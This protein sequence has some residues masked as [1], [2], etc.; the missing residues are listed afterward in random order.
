M[1][2]GQLWKYLI[3]AVGEILLVVIGILIALQ[4]NNWNENQK[5]K[6]AITVYLKSYIEDLEDDKK[7]LSD[8]KELNNFRYHSLQHLLKLAGE[9]PNNPDRIGYVVPPRSDSIWKGEFPMEFNEAFIHL[10][11]NYSHRNYGHNLNHSTLDELKSIG[12]YSYIEDQDLKE[13]IDDYYS[14]WDRRIGDQI[15]Q[16]NRALIEKW[17]DSFSGMGMVTSDPFVV[18]NPLLSIKDNP[19]AITSLRRLIREA[20]WIASSTVVIIEK[21]DELI[22]D[23]QVYI[24]N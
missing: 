6:K 3:Y 23:I 7:N 16:L 18:E 9:S 12:L 1:D 14:Q 22:A 15:A 2:E 13:S 21:A 20:G 17:Q 10:A 8:L 24:D 19:V 5:N 11:F 4:I